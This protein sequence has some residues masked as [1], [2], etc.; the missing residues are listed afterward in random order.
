M[1]PLNP[2]K[3]PHVLPPDAR[4]ECGSQVN[5]THADDRY[6]CG[7][8]QALEIRRLREMMTP[9]VFWPLYSP[10]WGEAMDAIGYYITDELG[11]TEEQ[12]ADSKGTDDE[13]PAD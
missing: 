4:C 12:A 10:E 6:W 13:V 7:C 3:P 2:K 11:M 1:A 8:C 5:L 9:L